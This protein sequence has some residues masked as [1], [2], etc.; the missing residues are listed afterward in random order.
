MFQTNAEFLSVIGQFAVIGFFL[1]IFYD[2]IRL[3]RIVFGMGKVFTFITDVLAML[4]SGLV[5]IFFGVDTP[6]GKLRLLYIL[7]AAFG[8]VLYLI[9]IGKITVYPARLAGKLIGFIKSLFG[10]YII[11]PICKFFS[12]IK[13]KLTAFFVELQQKN[14]NY[15]EKLRIGL[16]KTPSVLYNSNNNKMSKL[17]QNGGEERNVIKAKVRKKA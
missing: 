10:K 16:K 9:T 14:K 12:F 6:T 7:A 15:Q 1:G 13:Q 3:F 17:C 8:M 2:I 4:L 5:L 11:R